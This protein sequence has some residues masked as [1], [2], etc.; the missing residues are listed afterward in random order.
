[1]WISP[2]VLDGPRIRLR[3][4]TLEDAEALFAVADP[5]VFAFYVAPQLMNWSLEG[6]QD[7]LR[8][9]LALPDQISYVAEDRESGAMLGE[10]SFMD[11]RPAARG[12]EIGRTW[13]TVSA[14]GTHVNPEAKALMLRHA[15]EELGALRVTLKADAANAHSIA[16]MRKL[17]A[18]EE[19]LLR[20][21]GIRKDGTVRDTIYFGITDLDWPDVKSKLWTRLGWE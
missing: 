7:Y 20:R 2:I 15:F 17:G 12:L 9:R 18:I 21:H 3:P 4:T 14:R 16:A 10:T 8:A 13:W 6:F 1:M 19:G 5:Q 11:I